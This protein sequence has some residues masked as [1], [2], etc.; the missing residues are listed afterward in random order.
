MFDI[1]CN[2]LRP[3]GLVSLPEH[4]FEWVNKFERSHADILSTGCL[5]DVVP[6]FSLVP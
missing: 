5:K 4:D 6:R 1:Y 3:F 2:T